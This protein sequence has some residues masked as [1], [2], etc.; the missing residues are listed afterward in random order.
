MWG[1]ESFAR[2]SSVVIWTPSSRAES[3]RKRVLFGGSPEHGVA[4]L[5]GDEF[6]DLTGADSVHRPVHVSQIEVGVEIN[7][8]W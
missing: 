6:S 4:E 8:R 1:G 5:L 2:W 7:N 3:K